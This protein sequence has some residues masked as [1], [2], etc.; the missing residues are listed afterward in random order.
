M[1]WRHPRAEGRPS[2]AAQQHNKKAAEHGS[3]VFDTA[4]FSYPEAQR[5]SWRRTELRRIVMDNKFTLFLSFLLQSCSSLTF[6]DRAGSLRFLFC[7]P[8]L[9]WFGL[10]LVQTCST[11]MTKFSSRIRVLF[12]FGCWVDK[13]SSAWWC[14]DWLEPSIRES[15][16]TAGKW[17]LK[18][19]WNFKM[20]KSSRIKS[21]EHHI[22]KQKQRSCHDSWSKP[23]Q[24]FLGHARE[25]HWEKSCETSAVWHWFD[26]RHVD[27]GMTAQESFK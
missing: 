10:K 8:T 21:S 7:V 6:T 3:A 23:R 5:T 4:S 20:E 17:L 16:V 12:M 26:F 9:E 2:A 13:D 22:I 11:M 24:Q 19:L 15:I 27:I 1:R 18:A 25:T 14:Y